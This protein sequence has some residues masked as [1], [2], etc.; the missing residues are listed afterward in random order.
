MCID[1]GAVDK[2]V[3]L[4]QHDD[5]VVK[6]EAI[7]A[8]SN[9]TASADSTQFKIL[10]DKGIIKALGCILQVKDV[11]MLAVSLEGLDN[12]L[13]SGHEHFKNEDGD[14]TFAIIMEQEG[15]LDSLEDLQQHP[16]HNIYSAALKI[17]D[18]Y[19]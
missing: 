11:R 15:L 16:N 14:N 6:N 5:M 8:L 4:L 9:C 17:I 3:H 1:V 19:F 7:W 18:K 13:A 10:V 2:L 12:V